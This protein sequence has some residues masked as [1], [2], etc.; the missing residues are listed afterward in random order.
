MQVELPG[1][2]FGVAP[3]HSASIVQDTQ[4]PV[5]RLQALPEV[6]LVELLTEH[7]PHEPFGWQAGVVPP[8]CASV[9]QRE[10]VP[11]AGSHAGKFAGQ[12]LLVWH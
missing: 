6:Q 5:V 10:Q 11:D 3:E 2:H 8:H 4:D 9:V 7:W 12:S 1:S